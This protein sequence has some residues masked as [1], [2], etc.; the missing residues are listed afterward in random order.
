MSIMNRL[1]QLAMEVYGEFGFDTL[2]KFEQE[3]VI[4]LHM[5]DDIYDRTDLI[6]KESDNICE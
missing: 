6:L 1:D 4:S 3:L 2:T 5:L